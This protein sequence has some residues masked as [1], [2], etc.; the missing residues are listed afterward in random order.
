M[1]LSGLEDHGL[2]HWHES[3]VAV[4]DDEDRCDVVGMQTLGD[5]D[6]G[7]TVSGSDDADGGRIVE[8]ESQCGCEDHGDEDTTLSCSSDEDQPRLGDKRPEIDHGADS[9][10]E[11]KRERLCALDTHIVQPLQNRI[12]LKHDRTGQVYENRSETH[13][14]KERGLHLLPD[15]EVY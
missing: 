4:G 2:Y 7:R 6:G 9:D 15:G 3:H 5:Q 10:E 12:V 11:K 14:E 13:G 8:R 1:A